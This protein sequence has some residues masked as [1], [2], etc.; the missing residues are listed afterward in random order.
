MEPRKTSGLSLYDQSVHSPTQEG[1]NT[2]R[3]QYNPAQRQY[4]GIFMESELRNRTSKAWL[5][6]RKEQK[7]KWV[8]PQKMLSRVI[9]THWSGFLTRQAADLSH[10]GPVP[11][12][13]E[14]HF[15]DLI[16]CCR[17]Y[18]SATWFF[19]CTSQMEATVVSLTDGSV[20]RLVLLRRQTQ[21]P[22]SC[23]A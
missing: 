18:Q 13:F 23:C 2:I 14:R 7:F 15:T 17:V 6:H 20:T 9:L 4:S 3:E 1:M 5:Q 11:I 16:Q 21:T 8:E 12:F 22:S 10:H 19:D